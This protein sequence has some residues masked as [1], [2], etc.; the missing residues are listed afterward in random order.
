MYPVVGT[1]EDY[2]ERFFF[3]G[4]GVEKVSKISRGVKSSK[5]SG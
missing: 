1:I 2:F 5:E 4:G 3:W